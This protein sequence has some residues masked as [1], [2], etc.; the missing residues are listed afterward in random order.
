MTAAVTILGSVIFS[1]PLPPLLPSQ[2]ERKNPILLP[3]AYTVCVVRAVIDS[4][5][6]GELRLLVFFDYFHAKQMPSHDYVH[7]G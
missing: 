5:Y 6:Y 3:S 1:P 7:L 2:E 4:L